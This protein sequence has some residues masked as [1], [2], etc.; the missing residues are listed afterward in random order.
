MH[1]PTPRLLRTL[2]AL[3][4]GASVFVLSSTPSVAETPIKGERIVICGHSFHVMIGSP[5]S[6]I[7]KC[8]KVEGHEIVAAQFLGGSRVIQHW[9]LDDA[10]DRVRKELRTGKVDVLTLS[11]H[12]MLPDE[13]IDLF[14]KLAVEHNPKI[15][16]FVQASWYPFD[17]PKK[18]PKFTNDS[19]DAARIEDLRAGYQP[20]YDGLKNQ[21][22]TVND[23]Y[24][25]L[26]HPVAFLVPVGH[27]VVN[28]RER[29]A[30]GKVPGITKQSALFLDG[31]GHARGP[32]AVLAAYCYY[33]VIYRQS[34][35]GLPVP[36]MIGK[37]KSIAEPEKLNRLLQE[38]AWDAVTSEPLSGVGK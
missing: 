21:V 4:I 26:K 8:A 16:I 34:P 37:D 1:P 27:A 38:L 35:I 10:N 13:G 24:Q 31:I 11:P 3:L 9:K 12:V 32:V 19:R 25:A 15:R 36:D 18:D 28:L 29:V 14:T 7:V 17:V 20:F 2:A 5:M 33:S 6:Q 23:T 30:Q 22:T